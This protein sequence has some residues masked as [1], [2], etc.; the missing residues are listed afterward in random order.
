MSR[1]KKIFNFLLSIMSILNGYAF[2]FAR[3]FSIAMMISSAYAI[4]LIL[5]TFA[6]K[7][8]KLYSSYFDL[9]IFV[10]IVLLLTLFSSGLFV[11]NVDF[12]REIYSI[13]KLLVWATYIT[14]GGFY[15]FDIS[16]LVKYMSKVILVTFTFLIVQFIMHF[17]MHISFPALYDLKIIK[18]SSVDYEYIIDSSASVFRPGSLWGEPGYLGYYYN[19]FLCICLFGRES[20]YKISRRRFYII[21]TIIGIIMSMSSGAI[22]IMIIL[23]LFKL[24]IRKKE[25]HSILIVSC[26]VIFMLVYC[27]IQFGFISLLQGISPSLDN[28]IWKLQN[29]SSVGRVGKSFALID[30]LN[31]INKIIGVGAG[32][33]LAITKGEYMNGIVTL[34]YWVGFLG[35]TSWIV[36][37]CD[38]L[39]HV[40]KSIL[41]KISLLVLLFDGVFAGL[42]FGAHS[43]IY[44]LVAFY[45]FKTSASVECNNDRF[46]LDEVVY[47]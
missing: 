15:L 12:S 34:I 10:V 23:L 41:Q 33:E 9:Y 14:L 11:D 17:V 36:I 39:I 40:C 42:Y 45:E 47:E 30:R 3:G 20:Q 43:F 38:L 27:F 13:L 8:V 29:L 16:L 18:P 5:Y 31:E 2:F 6:K 46:L 25:K 37:S 22:G 4:F 44:L 28:T 1:E 35:L 26:I 7:E 24:L 32:N 19:S 21:I